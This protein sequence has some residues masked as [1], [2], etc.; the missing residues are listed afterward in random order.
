MDEPVPTR[1]MRLFR[2]GWIAFMVVAASL[3]PLWNYLETPQGFHYTWV[4]PP[5]PQDILA[6]MAWSEQA[7]GGSVLFGIKYTSIPHAPFLFHP[8]F[9]VCGWLKALLPW[10]MGVIHWLVKGVGIILFWLV[11]F[12]YVDYLKLDPLPNVAA[13]VLAGTSS[14]FGWIAYRFFG[15]KNNLAE[16]PAD[17]W[18][19]DVN[20]FWSLSWNP[21]F[22][23]SLTVL[24]LSLYSLDR[25]SREGKAGHM[26]LSGLAA[27]VLALIH[28]Y[29]LPLLFTLAAGI[30]FFRLRGKAAGMLMR[31][32]AAALP[33]AAIVLLLSIFN[34]LA[35]RHTLTGKMESGP[36][37]SYLIGFGLPLILCLTGI[38]LGRGAFLKKY[39][40]PLSWIA[41]AF[42]FA[43]LPFWFQRR[44]I[45]GVHVPLCLLAGASLGILSE[46]VA[47]RRRKIVS[48]MCAL[49]M[50]PL[51]L[52]TQ[53]F[54]QVTQRDSV[55]DNKQ[56]AFYI[57]DDLMEGLKY[58]KDGSRP[59]DLVF[60]AESTSIFVPVYAG[61]TV[62]WGHW[63]LTVDLQERRRWVIEAFRRGMG[64]GFG[65][66]MLSAG[67]RYILVDD[68]FRSMF[69]DPWPGFF[70]PY[71]K[72]FERG[73][74]TIY[75][76]DVGA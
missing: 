42:V 73:P 30:T 5:Y 49:V 33:F 50:M 60:A 59:S 14:G 9:L 29:C 67:V 57:G 74:V 34:P 32:F 68:E 40:L 48:V 20:T 7:A 24:L 70:A 52:S 17:L 10:D 6:Y 18:I 28:P 19:P 66:E 39:A 36:L 76:Y 43:Y 65:R 37:L 54:L 64:G 44:F 25:G 31:F 62:L 63:A 3:P 8:L 53:V 4:T 38:V 16:L 12:R 45:F 11:F 35:A 26:W 47:S 61:N 23:F 58:L 55:R 71:V 27:G 51:A 15:M 21:L 1:R 69:G 41:L 72:V 2:A 13:T 75:R 22:A 46:R 56:G